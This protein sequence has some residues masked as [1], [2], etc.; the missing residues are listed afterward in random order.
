MPLS[1]TEIRD[2]AVQFQ[3]RWKNETSEQ[4]ES[5]SFWKELLK[6]RKVCSRVVAGIIGQLRTKEQITRACQKSTILRSSAWA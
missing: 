3:K 1:W 2:R 4:A 5:Q 6:S